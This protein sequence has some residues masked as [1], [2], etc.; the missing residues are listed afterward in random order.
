MKNKDAPGQNCQ[1]TIKI[2]EPYHSA[3]KRNLNEVV[4]AKLEFEANR[5]IAN[6]VLLNFPNSFFWL[7]GTA[8][9]N[10]MVAHMIKVFDRVK[11]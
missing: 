6:K 4:I 10:D 9:F 5:E 8:L 7:S 2:D 1:R 3:L 11:K